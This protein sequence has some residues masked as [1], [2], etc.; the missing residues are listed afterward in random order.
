MQNGDLCDCEMDD[1]YDGPKFS[2][3]YVPGCGMAGTLG[4]GHFRYVIGK[5]YRF[6]P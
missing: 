1:D 3:T 4:S 6:V 2:Y 5:G